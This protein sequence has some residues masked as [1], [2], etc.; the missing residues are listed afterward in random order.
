M[1]SILDFFRPARAAEGA[2]GAA[3]VFPVEKS[4]IDWRKVLSPEQYRVLRQHGTER[5]GSSPLE[6]DPRVG[7]FYCA[8]CGNRLFRS[9]T[10]FDS[11][12]GWPSF[13]EAV[14]GAT[15]TTADNSLGMR[16]VEVHCSRCGGHLGHIF[17]DGPAPTGNR[18]C[19][20]GVAMKFQAD[21]K[22]RAS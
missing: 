9:D 18:F 22:G 3:K 20:N 16:R 12:C 2:S 7:T 11:G 14:P 21:D 13:F 8:G 19:M 6:H 17:N 5:P 10:K 1:V 15:E 4:D